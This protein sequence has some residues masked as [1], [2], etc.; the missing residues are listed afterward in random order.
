[1]RISLCTIPVEPN[2][3]DLVP[4]V[5]PG[6]DVFVSPRAEG[7]AVIPK[8]AIVSLVHWMEKHGYGA[9]TYDYYDIDMELPSDERLERYFREYNPT[10]IGLSGVVSTCYFQVRRIAKIA[11]K[12]CPDAWI[13]LG[14]SL[15][16][17]ANLVLRKTDVD[18]CVVGDG[19]IAWVNFLDYVKA[20][21]RRKDEAALAGIQGLAFI[22]GAGEL[23]S[24]GYGRSIGSEDMPFPD[25]DLLRTGLKD[26]PEDLRYHFRPASKV[27][28]L[29]T[30][31]RSY[32]PHRKPNVAIVFSSKGCVARCTFCQRSTK[33][34]HVPK[35]RLFEE[36][37]VMLKEKFD[38]GF[39]NFGDENFASNM[40]Y[41][42]E[43]AKVLKKHDMLWM[44]SGVRVSSVEP[45]D[46]RFFKEHGCV[47]IKFGIE[48]GSQKIMNVMEKKFTPQRVIDTLKVCA[49][50]DLYSGLGVMVGMPGETNETAQETGRFVGRLMHMQGIDPAHLE[51]AI[52]Y[53]LPLTGTPLYRYGQQIGLIGKVPE[54]EER[55]LL[56]VSGSGASKVNYVNLNGASL[57]DVAFWD[58]LVKLESTRTFLELE[59]KAPINRDSFFYKAIVKFG[60]SKERGLVVG[61]PLTIFQVINRLRMGVPTGIKGKIFYSIDNFLDNHVVYNEAWH[62]LPRWALYGFVQNLVY[63]NYLFQ[64]F[65][66]WVMG[67][68][69][70]LYQ[71]RP[72]VAALRL[73]DQ[74][75]K[76]EIGMSLRTIVKGLDAVAGP[77]GQTEKNQDV[78][79]I[80]L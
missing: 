54:E 20:H 32:E 77:K 59:A 53:A 26:R 18:L 70:N 64:K 9:D 40:T 55:Y 43:I 66:A 62:R 58:W 47:S 71:P 45:E 49:E 48:S 73:E 78:L 75:G 22:D 33:G 52:F 63:A 57:R 74:P 28:E 36:H 68:R 10:V 8:V 42:Y 56:E 60:T 79:A 80:G 34:Y 4:K 25:Y 3:E 11:R 67:R 41:T 69:F 6:V 76:V 19:E 38:V 61:R 72:Q 65:A 23:V 5:R 12:V 37:I 1:M 17:S 21:G 24:S 30:D 27:I 14:G 35:S 29:S 50:L 51:V 15:T 2:Y 39:I 44:V 46:L 16:A 7:G 13:V 31:P